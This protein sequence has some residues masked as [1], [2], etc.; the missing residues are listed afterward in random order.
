[1]SNH[2]INN[3]G[4]WKKWLEGDIQH[5][6]ISWIKACELLWTALRS[7]SINTVIS[8]KI[9]PEQI[10]AQY[11]KSAKTPLKVSLKCTHGLAV[12]TLQFDLQSKCKIISILFVCLLYCDVFMLDVCILKCK[13][14]YF[15]LWAFYIFMI[16]KII[17]LILHALNAFIKFSLKQ[18]DIRLKIYDWCNSDAS[19]YRLRLCKIIIIQ[20]FSSQKCITSHRMFDLVFYFNN[21]L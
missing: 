12:K 21:F 20:L 2:V 13:V 11:T 3:K 14:N 6:F 8:N 15:I 9:N 5:T 16:I 7:P 17:W 19:H 10:H 18:Y 4:F 1:M